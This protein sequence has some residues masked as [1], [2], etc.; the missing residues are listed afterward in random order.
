MTSS[1]F[2]A[3]VFD[4]NRL[5]ADVTVYPCAFVDRSPLA[6]VV[7]SGAD[8]MD[9][10]GTS[11]AGDSCIVVGTTTGDCTLIVVQPPSEH[12]MDR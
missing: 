2:G 12:T 10:R 6:A 9:E 7:R 5:P 4:V 11:D 8:D 3:S 1:E